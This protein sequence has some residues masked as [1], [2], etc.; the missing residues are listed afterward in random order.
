[1]YK[2]NTMRY[3]FGIILLSGF[4]SSCDTNYSASEYGLSV[5][6]KVGEIL[7]VTEKG[8]WE[9]D[10][11][12]YLDTNLTQF[13]MPYFPDVATFE[14]L[15]RTPQAFETGN[16]RW[17]NLLFISIDPTISEG[18]ITKESNTW[19]T[20]QL[21]YRIIAKDINELS[22]LCKRNLQHV[23]A[24][25]DE[26]EWKRIMTRYKN[27]KNNV[28]S[29]NI[30]KHFGIDLAFPKGSSIVSKRANFYRVEIP[31]DTKPMEFVGDATGQAANFIQTGIL[32][33]QYD[34]IDSSQ[35]NI[36]QL[37]QARDTMLKYNVPHENK[38]VYMG[39]QYAKLVAPEGNITKTANKKLTAFENRGMFKFTGATKHGSGGAFWAYHFIHPTRKKVMCVSGY[40][41]APS[42]T[43]WTL[44][45]RE[46][47]AILKSV[48]IVE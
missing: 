25:F 30:K 27:K 8:I 37:L 44:P 14:L 48:E 7:V 40:V 47:Q 6:G 42:M 13:I 46:I 45:L 5:T 3:L 31:T 19:A 35:F 1:M 21:V 16:K 17:R 23:H 33:Y 18:K 15:H 41:D 9:S 22:E 43:S 26:T 32:I 38:G 2:N 4:L 10:V 20:G 29:T 28:L 39:T 11:K 24:D 34:Y 12:A 36:N